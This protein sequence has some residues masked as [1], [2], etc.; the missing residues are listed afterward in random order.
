MIEEVEKAVEGTSYKKYDD[1]DELCKV[2]ADLLA[3][4]KII[5]WFQ[6]RSE[7]GPRALGSRSNTNESKTKE[8]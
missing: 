7:F 8:E 3:D 4:N 2:T 6:N 5:G 1:F